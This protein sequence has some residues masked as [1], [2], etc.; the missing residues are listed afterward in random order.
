MVGITR[1]CQVQAGRTR[2]YSSVGAGVGGGC[3][4]N[5]TTKRLLSLNGA[6]RSVVSCAPS[7]V[8]EEKKS[9]RGRLVAGAGSESRL[10]CDKTSTTRECGFGVRGETTREGDMM[11]PTPL[12]RVGVRSPTPT[13]CGIDKEHHFRATGGYRFDTSLGCHRNAKLLPFLAC[14]FAGSRE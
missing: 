14:L 12:R 10:T 11:R 2:G 3:A 13:S 5:L 4:V 1:V 9:S 8:G 7:G 6:W